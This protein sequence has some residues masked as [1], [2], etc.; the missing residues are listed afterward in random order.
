MAA[1]PASGLPLPGQ[2]A[3]RE[4]VQTA[5]DPGPLPASLRAGGPS[6]GRAAPASGRLGISAWSETQPASSPPVAARSKQPAGAAPPQAVPNEVVLHSRS[7]L[8]DRQ[9]AN[10]G[11]LGRLRLLGQLHDSFI[12]AAA[13]DGV[14]I[15][16]QHVAHER[17]LFEKVL[18]ARLN[19]RP[20]MQ[21]LLAPIVM[22]LTPSQ[23][24]AYEELAEEFL[25]NGFEV[26]PFGGRTIAIKATPAELSPR[27]VEALIQELLD[28]SR[29]AGRGLTLGQLRKRMAATIACHASIK[30]NMPLTEEKMRWLLEQLARTDCPMSCPHGRPIALRYDTRQILK[31]FHRI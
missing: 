28:D 27:D 3:Q 7:A 6:G 2:I 21:R 4:R 12:V 1:K 13:D 30:V 11:E 8:V 22:T 29:E 17:I 16:D 25:G 19:G 9:P 15:I 31:A 18:G 5:A 24:V 10:L 14:W 26:E 20:E 23:A